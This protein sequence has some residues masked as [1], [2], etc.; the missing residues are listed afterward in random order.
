[1][2]IFR[3]AFKVSGNC[4]HFFE[5]V[6]YVIFH[7]FCSQFWAY[8]D[9]CD[10]IGPLLVEKKLQILVLSFKL[11]NLIFHWFRSYFGSI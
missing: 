3:L 10:P 5:I 11:K 9:T 1:M 8:L 4:T 7:S 2:V 6:R